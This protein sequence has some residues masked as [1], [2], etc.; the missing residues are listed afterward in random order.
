MAGLCFSG[1]L[2]NKDIMRMLSCILWDRLRCWHF[3]PS[4]IWIKVLDLILKLSSKVLFQN[5]KFSWRLIFF[6]SSTL[7]VKLRC[8]WF[9]L[10]SMDINAMVY[11]RHSLDEQKRTGMI[12]Q[13]GKN[14]TWK[15]SDYF[16]SNIMATQSLTIK[17]ISMWET[18]C[19]EFSEN[20]CH[21]L[22]LHNPIS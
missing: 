2:L 8:Q 15:F 5:F 10:Q 11:L 19:C 3:I 13:V 14:K 17:W 18:F 20:Y 4:R 12:W 16:L 9:P 22:V 21:S 6:F 7:C 1:L